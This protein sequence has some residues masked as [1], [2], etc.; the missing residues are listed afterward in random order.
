MA[1]PALEPEAIARAF[2]LQ[3]YIDKGNPWAN[4]KQI[5]AVKPTVLHIY[6][7][8][9]HVVRAFALNTLPKRRPE[10]WFRI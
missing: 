6:K 4:T 10:L 5:N 1:S 2:E 9:S 7:N 8:Y 3:Q